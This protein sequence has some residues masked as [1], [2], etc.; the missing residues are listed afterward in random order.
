MPRERKD[1]KRKSNCRDTRECKV[2]D[3]LKDVSKFVKNLMTK[4]SKS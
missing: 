4:R 2:K 3:T 1:L